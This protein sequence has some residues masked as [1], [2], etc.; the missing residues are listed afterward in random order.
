MYTKMLLEFMWEH[1]C[2]LKKYGCWTL[3]L[4]IA[5]FSSC[6]SF[7]VVVILKNNKSRSL[8]SVKSE[9]KKIHSEIHGVDAKNSG[10]RPSTETCYLEVYLIG[11]SKEIRC[12][13]PF[14]H[15]EVLK[16]PII[17]LIMLLNTWLLK[18][19]QFQLPGW[20]QFIDPKI[21][22]SCSTLSITCAEKSASNI[23]SALG[24]MSVPTSS[25]VIW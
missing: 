11:C 21:L 5:F 1:S 25:Y 9:S 13:I 20:V 8:P 17:T 3:I 4:I 18:M 6:P 16:I 7:G 2:V 22:N 14:P 23:R 10:S 19:Q 15:L 24:Q 12:K